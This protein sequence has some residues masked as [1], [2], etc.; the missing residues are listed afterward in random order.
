MHKLCSKKIDGVHYI[1]G[2]R[3][4]NKPGAPDYILEVDS[5]P[6]DREWVGA[7]G[8]LQYRIIPNPAY[9]AEKGP[10]RDN[11][12]YLLEKN[13]EP[14]S[15]EE[16]EAEAQKTITEIRE[17]LARFDLAF[18]GRQYSVYRNDSVLPRAYLVSNYYLLEESDVLSMLKSETFNPRQAV[19]LEQDPQVP[20]QE[21]ERPL[22]EVKV[23]EYSAN[24]VVCTPDCPYPGF[25]ILTDNWHPD[26]KVFVD[27]EESTLYRANYTFRAVYLSQG[28]HEVVFAYVSSYFNAGRIISIIALVLSIGLCVLTMR[29]KI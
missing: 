10:A 13:P 17:Y 20:H 1:T 24:R 6:Q 15:G 29:F 14:L 25:L 23:S 28:R 27:G 22:V 21:R 3:Y 26:W 7:N 5:L 19:V 4:K 9:D 11:R 12:P 18:S 2:N 8:K 16:L